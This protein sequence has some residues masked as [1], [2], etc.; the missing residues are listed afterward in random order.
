MAAALHDPG[1]GY[2]AR[3]IRGVGQRGD[4]T[5]TAALSPALGKAIAAWANRALRDE[6]C[7]DLIELGPGEGMLAESIFRNLPWHRRLTTRLHLVE[8]SKPLREK[9]H[10]R[11]GS[12]V[13]WHA[14]IEDALE[15]CGGNACIF[16]NEFADAFPVRRFRKSDGHLEEQYLLPEREVWT[17]VQELPDST[18][19]DRTWNEQQTIEVHESYHDWILE[20][21]PSWQRGRLLTIDYGARAEDLYHRQ[22]SG[23]LRAYF[24]QQRFT[25]P[26]VW[27]RAGHQ[28]ITADVN[29]S[30]L[31]QW[32]GTMTEL[33]SLIPQSEFLAPHID[34][35]NPAD[36]Y[37]IDPA[38]PGSAFLCLDQRRC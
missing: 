21:L 17:P 11:L 28:D 30:D 18:L 16:S 24:H 26:E 6:E 37:A 10:E 32:P 31:I 19:L 15:S 33:V 29:F 12:K 22:P 34:P 36:R 20:M 35:D 7:R 9:Q 4:F 38:G 23:S 25:G 13:S 3:R 14:S 27:A 2:Y 8:T 1:Q 5:T